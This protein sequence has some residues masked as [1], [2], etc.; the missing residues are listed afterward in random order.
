[1]DTTQN[2]QSSQSIAK[3][4]QESYDGDFVL[5]SMVSGDTP[6]K[7]VSDHWLKTGCMSFAD[8]KQKLASEQQQIDD[9]L[10]PLTEWDVIVTATGIAF[11][12]LPTLREYVPTD[13]ALNLMCQPSRMSSWVLRNMR[14]PIPHATKKDDDGEPEVIDGGER[15][16]ADYEVLRDYI[17]VHL[18]NP[19]RVDQDKVRLFRT[20][21]DGT[22]RAFLSEQYTIVNNSWFLSVLEK[23]VPGG[24]VSHWKGDADSIFGN[25]L[26]PDTIRQEQDSDFGGML[27]VGNSEIGTRRISS[28]PSV[29]RAICMNGC[30]WD[31][32]VGKALSKVHRGTVDFNSLAALI[33]ENLQSQIPLLAGGIDTVLNL[34]TFGCGDTPLMSLLAQTAVDYSMSKKQVAAVY[35]GWTAEMSLLGPTDAKTAYGLTNAITRAG[36]TFGSNEQWV[37]FD[38]IGGEFVN[39][40]RNGWDKFRS[41]A[42]GLTVKQVD[43]RIGDLVIA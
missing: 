39:M 33:V 5:D 24:V 15:G 21:T 40:G 4:G 26:I 43:K 29:F 20:W 42:D 8:A 41:R 3:E 36:Q 23:A 6:F 16:Q 11:R 19:E 2:E 7:H 13:H 10:T 34:R 27:S 22:L 9:H 32:E 17:N 12:H 38:T 37:R 18:F 1:M 30:I 28:M 35:K 14:N 31:Q 25:I